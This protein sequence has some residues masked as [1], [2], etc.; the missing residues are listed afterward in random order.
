MRPQN[1][2]ACL[3]YVADFAD[4]EMAIQQKVY[5]KSVGGDNTPPTYT[6]KSTRSGKRA[7]YVL[8][9]NFLPQ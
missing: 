1:F 3:P 8:C 4:G 2:K 6:K 7:D 9:I 5:E